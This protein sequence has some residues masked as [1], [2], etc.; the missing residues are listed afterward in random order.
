MLLSLA[1]VHLSPQDC[2]VYYLV[3]SLSSM[4]VQKVRTADHPLEFGAQASAAVVKC[5][6]S[7]LMRGYHLRAQCLCLLNHP[8]YQN[9]DLETLLLICLSEC[10]QWSPLQPLTLCKLLK[11]W[12]GTDMIWCESQSFCRP[13]LD[14]RSVRRYLC[15]SGSSVGCRQ[16]CLQ[17]IILFKFG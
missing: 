4:A 10:C 8:V 1:I 2:L 3:G 9:L 7:V 11:A 13:N 17:T 5:F 14:H 15:P 16:Y 6:D 12:D